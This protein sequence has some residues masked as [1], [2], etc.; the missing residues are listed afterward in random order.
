MNRKK[1]WD[2]SMDTEMMR[3]NEAQATPAAAP[4]P[5]LKTNVGKMT[6]LVVV[7]FNEDAKE[8]M[9]DKIDRMIRREIHTGTCG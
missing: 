1:G 4:D 7:H 9:A 2:R 6:Y 8:T 3:T 5:R